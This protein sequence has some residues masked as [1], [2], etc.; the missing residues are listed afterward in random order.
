MDR[1]YPGV[2]PEVVAA[3][4]ADESSGRPGCTL[5]IWRTALLLWA[6]MVLCAQRY[7]IQH[8]GQADGLKNLSVHDVVQD[9]TGFLWLATENGVF[10]FDG[11][12]SREFGT[13]SG[14]PASYVFDLCIAEDDRLWA[15]TTGGV[16]YLKGE[17]FQAVSM[18]EGSELDPGRVLSCAAPGTVY[19]A[20]QKGLVRL[21]E[22]GGKAGG[23]RLDLGGDETLQ[24]TRGVFARRDG[25]IWFGCQKKLCVWDPAENRASIPG[26]Q[27]NLP[28]EQWISMAEDEAGHMWLRRKTGLIEVNPQTG[29][30]FDR[31]QG[32]PDT[33]SNGE[34]KWIEGIG[35][36]V[37][38][39][40]GG[41]AL[42]R[43]KWRVYGEE[44]G[45]LVS[46]TTTSMRDRDGSL[47][48]ATA[49]GGL[50]RLLGYGQWSHYTPK[51][52]MRSSVIWEMER[53]TNGDLW[54]ATNDG[55]H[56]LHSAADEAV[57]WTIYGAKQGLQSDRTRAIA[58]APDGAVW[59]GCFV[60]GAARLDPRTGAV[61]RF[62]PATG[63]SEE[64]VMA[65]EID[66]A[67]DVWAATHKGVFRIPWRGGR[68]W[69][70]VEIPGL[71]TDVRALGLLVDK[72]QSVWVATRH[73]LARR[74]D[75]KWRVF[76]PQ[77][78]LPSQYVGSIA[79]GRDGRYWVGYREAVG[80]SSMTV[81]GDGTLAMRHYTRRDGLASDYCMFTGVDARGW[82]WYGSD[83][84]VDIFDGKEW[85]HHGMAD[86]VVWDDMDGNSFWADGDGVTWVGTSRGL[87][88]FYPHRFALN[89]PV[90][91]IHRIEAGR[92]HYDSGFQN[93]RLAQERLAIE[94]SSLVYDNPKA[95]RF[96]FR[97]LGLPE[98]TWE[99]TDEQVLR[100]PKLPP[101]SYVFEVKARNPQG[102][103]SVTPAQF[104]FEVKPAWWQTSWF[105]IA[106]GLLLAGFIW[107][108]H[109]W[110]VLALQGARRRLQEAVA[111]RTAELEGAKQKA[112]A[113][114]EAKTWFLA[115]M[116]HEIRTP[117]NGILG[118]TQLLLGTRLDGEQ[119]EM[120]EL[121][122]ASADGLLGVIN[123]VL[124]FSKV[125]AGKIELERI[126]FSVREVVGGTARALEAMAADKGLTVEWSC[127]D[128]LPAYV[129]GDAP[130]L[131]Q[132]LLN[133]VG[134]AIKFTQTG[135]VEIFAAQ[136]AAARRA[137]G[138]MV[139]E[140]EFSVRDSGIGIS[141]EQAKTIFE[142]FSQADK[143]MSRKY[144]GTGLG[145]T[146]SRR[147]VQMMGGTIEV[148]SELGIGSTFRVRLPMPVAEAPVPALQTEGLVGDAVF[149][150]P[151]KVLV[152]E[153]NTVNQVLA[154]RM[155]EK[156][157]HVVDV[158]G[159]GKSAVEAVAR[160]AYDLV[161]MDV[162]MPE[163]DGF[164]ATLEIRRWEAGGG[165]QRDRRI[166]IVALTANA[167]EG[168][169][170]LCLSRGMDAY[171]A[172][173]VRLDA[174][175]ALLEEVSRGQLGVTA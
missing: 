149:E 102:M 33:M 37:A 148:S 2:L 95:V 9:K 47:W 96:A 101:G 134:N 170:E 79:Q 31:G 133:L 73:G 35:I 109:W 78:G 83:N 147:L 171:L 68:R 142:A 106:L 168:D 11:T 63:I 51:E 86:G 57:R 58:V 135:K 152:A 56:R 89:P 3:M 123:D 49:G 137:D 127:P 131:R 21:Q 85:R 20:T 157:G 80:L 59:I 91:L 70:R 119:R 71:P 116:S 81:N 128:N 39:D 94:Y 28:R 55:V 92:K 130:R 15:A 117:L 14:L 167:M 53:D 27:W 12:R 90:A 163:M 173:P 164:E 38:T 17:G 40:Q 115:H 72:E 140:I 25:K 113:A 45:L 64:A 143:R 175:A 77:D 161:L 74:R 99:E 5:P 67:G 126:P 125:E 7:P 16:G 82:V 50:A 154:K 158:V 1:A 48:T 174:L 136:T 100:Y 114:N 169:R 88:S 120:L 44:S 69:E 46:M 144:G 146:I 32:L 41:A 111:D 66:G 65:L 36:S 23:A 160:G 139:A 19:V 107:L 141:S 4:P 42:T 98:S 165:A 26:R 87:A 118:M 52:G 84:G 76:T 121:S 61:T 155:L 8:Y 108:A 60:G 156:R 93:I 150:S 124:D 97:M 105:A 132:V 129:D 110:S 30:W 75:G 122:Q 159:D 138:V 62:G 112:E 10:R 104:A 153:D 29:E 172:K 166:P 43:G 162:Q 13:A 22:D 24:A 6:A 34:V 18:P 151:M 103:W 54:I 145:L